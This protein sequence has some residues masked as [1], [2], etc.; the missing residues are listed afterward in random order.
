MVAPL[1]KVATMGWHFLENLNT[2]YKIA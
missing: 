1:A 2:T